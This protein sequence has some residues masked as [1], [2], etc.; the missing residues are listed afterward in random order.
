LGRPAF[1]LRHQIYDDRN[2]GYADDE[3]CRV[4]ALLTPAWR[5]MS[6]PVPKKIGN[7][8]IYNYSPFTNT[9]VQ[10]IRIAAEHLALRLAG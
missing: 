9:G 7:D 2:R 4:C 6:P 5:E 1:Y 8:M 3:Q 10:Q